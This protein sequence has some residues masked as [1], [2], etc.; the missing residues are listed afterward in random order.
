MKPKQELYSQLEKE[1]KLS[2][3]NKKDITKLFRSFSLI[4]DN[5]ID[6]IDIAHVILHIMQLPV[7]DQPSL[8][9]ATARLID[10]TT[11]SRDEILESALC[12]QTDK[13]IELLELVTTALNNCQQQ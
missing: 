1:H 3:N 8:L 5:D 4:V 11:T 9:Y 6:N 12:N 10:M 2:I 7:P 13:V